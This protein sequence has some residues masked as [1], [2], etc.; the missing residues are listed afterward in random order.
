MKN[1]NGFVSFLLLL[2][3]MLITSC[4]QEESQFEGIPP[5]ERLQLGSNVANLLIRTTMNDGSI[6]NIIDNASCISVKLPV[7][8]IVNSTP[9]EV[10]SS[11]DFDL[12]QDIFD[13]S[14]TDEDTVEIQFPATIIFSDY[15]EVPVLNADDFQVF[16]ANCGG[17]DQN[18]DDI[19][20][21][22]LQYPI[23]ISLVNTA[24]GMI[25]TVTLVND[26]KLFRFVKDLEENDVVTIN[27]PVT[28]ILSDGNEVAAVDQNQL[29]NTIETYKDSCD[30]NDNND[31]DVNC[32][33]CTIEDLL[34][35]WSSCSEWKVDKLFR[36]TNSLQNQYK[37][38]SFNFL[39][40]GSVIAS[41]D[42]DTF[43]GTWVASGTGN[44]ITVVV[45]FLNL[46]DFNGSWNLKKIGNGAGKKKFEFSLDSDSLRFKDDCK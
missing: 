9:V 40:D 5:E 27:F 35:L 37:D 33:A 39:D 45:D 42:S 26:K 28:V 12:I 34:D 43:L 21:V 20:C 22:D 30:E 19:E 10:L 1:S 18:D 25:D 23:V 4:R 14:D 11:E 41:S 2:L 31:F 46:P 16:V 24:S 8:V 15:T 3:I 13:E 17:E 38:Y 36:D 29:E 32:A 44:N 6:D 7:N